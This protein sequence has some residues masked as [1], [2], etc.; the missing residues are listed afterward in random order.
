[1]TTLKAKKRLMYVV[2]GLIFICGGIEYAVILPSLWLYL[3]N[4][5]GAP[6]YMLGVVLSAYSVAATFC[7]PLWGRICDK[8]RKT[9]IIFMVCTCFEMGGSFLYFADI[10]LATVV[11]ARFISGLGAGSEAVVFAEV[12]RYSTEKD[13]TGMISRLA[14][15]RQVALLL[16]P[17]LNAFLKDADFKIGPFVVNSYTAP[18]AFL[19]CIWFLL[20]MSVL[21]MYH[22]PSIIFPLLQDAEDIKTVDSENITSSINHNEADLSIT[23]DPHY[24]G[25]PNPNLSNL[26]DM[27]I[28]NL[29]IGNSD[30]NSYSKTDNDTNQAT[31]LLPEVRMLSPSQDLMD[32]AEHFIT[33]ASQGADC[34]IAQNSNKHNGDLLYDKNHFNKDNYKPEEEFVG[35][36]TVSGEGDVNCFTDKR[37]GT[38]NHR[39]ALTNN[40]DYIE[41]SSEVLE[42]VLD[43]PVAREGKWGFFCNEYLR[44]EIVTLLYV[45]FCTMFAQVCVETMVTPL[46]LKYLDFGE[47]ENSLFYCACGVEILIVFIIVATLSRWV[48]DRDLI[49]FG[50]LVNLASNCWLI[51][52]LPSYAKPHDRDG[53]IVFFCVPVFL[54]VLSLPFLFVCSTS[55][56]SKLTR[57]QTQGLSQGVRRAVVG[58]GTIIAPLWGSA[59]VNQPYLLFGVLISLQALAL[60]LLLGSFKRLIPQGP[61]SIRNVRPRSQTGERQRLQPEGEE[62][63]HSR[64]GGTSSSL[65]DSSSNRSYGATAARRSTFKHTVTT[66]SYVSINEPTVTEYDR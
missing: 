11:A 66:E 36:Y 60:L 22:E 65:I 3:D 20:F 28:S 58:C 39:R 51:W 35:G 40:D 43:D 64:G 63:Q 37:E 23:Y 54:T 46:T 29:D 45:V 44:D 16:G 34:N 38:S 15:M 30:D 52:F 42:D 9:R 7:S 2:F 41:H 18:G 8:T 57:K 62:G 48:C 14:A 59:T 19:V 25:G 12:A 13:R 47:L 21:L 6:E 1:M 4:E 50:S 56:Y 5:Y 49:I 31:L 53:N 17:G 33:V 26:S 61:M 55:L 32:T 24:D 10:S 27:S